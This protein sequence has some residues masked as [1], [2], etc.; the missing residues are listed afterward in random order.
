MSSHPPQ[1]ENHRDP[2]K[3]DARRDG[4]GG[5]ACDDIDT[6]NIK[7]ELPKTGAEE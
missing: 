4:G 6:G 1:K 5:G 2:E 7:S 3:R